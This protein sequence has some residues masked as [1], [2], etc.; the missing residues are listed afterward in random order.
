MLKKFKKMHTSQTN[1]LITTQR[2]LSITTEQ[3][4]KTKTLI[5]QRRK[6]KVFFFPF[7]PLI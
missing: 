5:N 2:N 1:L 3:E 7:S 4:K 6:V